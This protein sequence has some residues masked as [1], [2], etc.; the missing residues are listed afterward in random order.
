MKKS[1]IKIG[2]TVAVLFIFFVLIIMGIIFWSRYSQ[3][4]LREQQ[5]VDILSQAIKVAQTASFLPE[6]QCSTLEVIKF[7]CFDLYKIQ[8]MQFILNDNSN[9]AETEA[10]RQHYFDSFGYANITVYSIYPESESWNI[11]D[12]TGGNFT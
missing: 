12:F 4:S 11:Y 7:S 1:Q 8:A 3:S 10:A 6:L 5:E 2:E 9:P